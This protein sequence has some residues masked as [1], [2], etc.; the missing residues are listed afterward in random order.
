MD[1]KHSSNYNPFH[2]I[3]D[4]NGNFVEDKLIQMIEVFMLNTKEEGASGGE[5]FWNDS[6]KLLLSAVCF[7][8]VEKC[9]IEDQNF[10]NVLRIIRMAHPDDEKRDELS[11]FDA[12]F[13]VWRI[14]IPNSLA[15]QYYDEFQQ[16]AGKTMQSILISTT[17][18][19]Q[20]FK[21]DN[22]KNLTFTDNIELEKLGDEKTA[23]FII[24]PS[25]D[26][27]YNFLAAMMYSQLFDT[28]CRRASEKYE[29]R[30]MKLPVHVRFILDE[31]ANVGKIPNFENVVAT[32]RKF[33]IS[34]TIILQNLSQ[35]K[36]MY[37]KAWG[38]IV[39][40][41]D[42]TI[43]LG[44]KDQTTNEFMVKDLGKETIDLMSINKTKSRQ[45]STSYNDSIIGRELLT[46]DELSRLD[47]AQEIVLLR[48]YPPFKTYKHDLLTHPRYKELGMERDSPPDCV[49]PLNLIFTER[50]VPITSTV[51]DVTAESLT[52]FE[53]ITFDFFDEQNDNEE[54]FEYTEEAKTM[55]DGAEV[56]GYTYIPNGFNGI[57]EN[58]PIE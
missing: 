13:E 17:V 39:G 1:M 16:A 56:T 6:T 24:I 9:P 31:F 47:N 8:L 50:E 2:Y 49:F 23:L 34:V 37:E 7:L 46:A 12:L 19:L 58:M 52:D 57:S 40:N 5:Q 14:E 45:G 10:A 42:S 21:L 41:C 32:I 33:E 26:K 28:L 30:G 3:Y 11:P 22:L 54:A 25:T 44:N 38:D 27:T 36:N 55:L 48:G 29:Y 35:L 43:F 15:V 18:R 20:H 51:S 53:D 4:W